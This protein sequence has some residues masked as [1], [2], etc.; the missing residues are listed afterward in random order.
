MVEVPKDLLKEAPK[1]AENNSV[2]MSTPQVKPDDVDVELTGEPEGTPIAEPSARKPKDDPLEQ[3]RKDM[4]AAQ[5]ATKEAQ[6]RAAS[7]ERERDA[8]RTQID[9]TKAT[10]AKSETEKVA[11]QEQAILTRVETAK[12]EVENAERALEEAIDTGKPAKEQIAL[13]KKLAEAVYKQK[14]AEGAKSHFDSWK[15]REKNK[16][17]PAAQQQTGGYSDSAQRW[18]DSRPEFKTNKNYKRLAEGAAVEAENNGIRADTPAYFKAIEDALRDAGFN[19]DPHS[20]D[21]VT[22]TQPKKPSSSGTS[23]A[24]PASHNS[25]EAGARGG[26]AAEEQRTGRRIF[27]LDGNMK[28]QAIRLYGKNSTFKLSD[29]EAFKR[30]AARQLEIRDKRANGEKI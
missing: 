6:D 10:L 2:I 1:L 16:P 12:A 28:D 29:E 23:T 25:T 21:T 27:K 7:A 5:K 9:T 18:I 15:E 17:A 14:G 8:A 13:Q 4:E 11:A 30:Y 3:M 26:N 22:A 24:A 20:A 19:A